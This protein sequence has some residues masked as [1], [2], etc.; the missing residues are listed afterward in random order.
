MKNKIRRER[1]RGVLTI[2][3]SKLDGN[4]TITAINLRAVAVVRYT[5][6]ILKW[7]KDEM[8]DLE[9]K[10]RKLLTMYRSFHRQGDVDRLCERG[11]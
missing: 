9:R 10:T 3:K 1:I 4:N 2:L 11:S 5:A 7:R 6:A 8:G